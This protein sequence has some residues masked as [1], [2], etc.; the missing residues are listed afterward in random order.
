MFITVDDVKVVVPVRN[1]STEFCLLKMAGAII[2]GGVGELV[3]VNVVEVPPQISLS[4]SIEAES[5]GLDVQKKILDQAENLVGSLDRLGDV[6]LRTRAI[7]G[8]DVGS[9]VLRVLE[10]EDADHLVI[11]W[12]GEVS[13]KDYVLGSKID[14]IVRGACCEVTVVKDG[15]GEDISI[16]C[17]V[18]EGPN[19][20]YTVKRAGQLR[21]FIDGDLTLVNYQEVDSSMSSEEV[22]KVK[23]VGRK[24]ISRM[25]EEAGLEGSFEISVVVGSN[26]KK[27]L[28]EEV[29]GYDY[30]CVGSVMNSKL[31]LDTL[32]GPLPEKIGSEYEGTVLLV[33][34]PQEEHDSFFDKMFKRFKG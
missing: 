16:A 8:R 29:R 14:P 18:G 20:L 34:G 21:E 2:G 5:R 10:E 4:Q 9:S 25:T 26:R 22:Y 33:R 12:D 23:R 17:L 19:T 13:K 24:L 30:V 6:S 28:L 32:F 7:V 31:N 3:V 27:R 11:G 15:V 1:P